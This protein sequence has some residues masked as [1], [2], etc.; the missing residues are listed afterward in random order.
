MRW[1]SGRSSPSTKA[2]RTVRPSGRSVL[3]ASLTAAGKRSSPSTRSGAATLVFC[4][5]FAI[6][7][8][9]VT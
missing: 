7:P 3:I 1:V 5:R 2:K 9:I 4:V 6:K 8:S